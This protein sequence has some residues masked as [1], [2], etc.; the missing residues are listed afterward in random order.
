MNRTLSIFLGLAVVVIV[1]ALIGVFT[2]A[3]QLAEL[4]EGMGRRVRA[5][6]DTIDESVEG[7]PSPD[8]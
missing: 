1:V 2:R 6:A 7:E 8:A 5:A 4:R 3:P